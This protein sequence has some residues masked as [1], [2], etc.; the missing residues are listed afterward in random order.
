VAALAL[1]F[2]LFA[3]MDGVVQ[4]IIGLQLRSDGQFLSTAS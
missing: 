4:V 1:L 2:G 3:V